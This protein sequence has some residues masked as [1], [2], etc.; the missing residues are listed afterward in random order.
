MKVSR[1][2]LQDSGI[3]PDYYDKT[4]SGYTG[5]SRH[6]ARVSKYIKNIETYKNKGLSFLFYGTNNSGKTTL[7]MI[8]CKAFLLE[9]LTCHVTSLRQLTDTFCKG[10]EDRS[11]IEHYEKRIKSCGLL[12][13]DD[14][15]KEFQNRMTA[16]VLD[17]VLRHRSNELLPFIVTTNC[18]PDQLGELYGPSFIALLER[19]AVFCEFKGKLKGSESLIDRN[20]KLLEEDDDA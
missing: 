16:A 20:L 7:A 14:L 2:V 11:L 10:W 1:S 3:T 4:L 12:V 19:R 15:N 18:S 13:I 17:E 6:A 8:L 9:G 5:P